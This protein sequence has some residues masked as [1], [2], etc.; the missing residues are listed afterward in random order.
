MNHL[1]LKRGEKISLKIHWWSTLK[2]NCDCSTQDVWQGP[3]YT[4]GKLLNW[5]DFFLRIDLTSLYLRLLDKYFRNFLFQL[6]YSYHLKCV[7]DADNFPKWDVSMAQLV[8]TTLK[9]ELH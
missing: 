2:R 9:Y 4:S 3:K 8:I 7:D 1:Q 5:L 6:Y